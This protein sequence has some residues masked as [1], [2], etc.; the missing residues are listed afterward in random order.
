MVRMALTAL[1][2]AILSIQPGH[3]ARGVEPAQMEALERRIAAG[4]SLA[5]LVRYA[6]SVNP[7]IE[8]AREAWRATVERYRITTAYPDPQLMMTYYPEPIETRLGPQDWNLNLTQ[9]LPF[10]GR[11]SKAGDVVEADA[12]IARL[13]LD[14]AIRDMLVKVRESYHELL[15]IQDAKKVVNLNRDLL[16]HLRKVGETSYAQDRAAFVDV[17]KAQ[18]QSAQ[19]QYDLI[20]LEDLEQTEKGRLNALLNRAPGKPIGRLLPHALSPVLYQIE[21]IYA[22]ANENREEIRM[23]ETG[24]ERASANKE[25]AFFENLPDFR[26]GFF[27]GGIGEPDVPVPPRDAG[28]DAVGVQFGLSIPL[29]FGKNQ[30]RMEEARAKE[31][32]ARA[33]KEVEVNEAHAQIR[34][35]YFRLKN[36][37]R[38]VRL[39]GDQL[40]PQ[41]AQAM[42]IS[43]TWFREGQGSFSDFVETQSAYY[44]FQLA[45]ARAKADYGKY[46]ALL[47]RFVGRSLTQRDD[48]ERDE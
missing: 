24:I 26:L 38:L 43:E 22:L 36:S 5:D 14:R 8:A 39:Y 3:Y 31:R 11:L 33:M 19:I 46:L 1:A 44:N 17:V 48:G 18:S 47:E 28:S 10:P 40:L 25:L 13:E 15:Y 23:A 45:L 20:L 42:E 29:W 30:G 32:R 21:E 9:A 4:P 16:D 34:S 37:E 41:A 12:R 2:A 27:Y 35:F 7:G 6:Y